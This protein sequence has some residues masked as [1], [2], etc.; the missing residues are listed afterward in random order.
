M[1]AD[2]SCLV[3]LEIDLVVTDMCA[4]RRAGLASLTDGKIKTKKGG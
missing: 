4:L 3:P 2:L 1:M